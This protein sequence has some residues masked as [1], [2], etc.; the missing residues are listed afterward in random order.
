MPRR[1]YIKRP[2]APVDLPWTVPAIAP[3]Y[4]YPRGTLPGG[5]IIGIGELGGGWTTADVAANFASVGQP[6]PTIVDVSVGGAT[7]SPGND[8]DYEVM[9]DIVMAGQAYYCV[10][11]KPATIRVYWAP[12]DAVGI[13]NVTDQAAADGC[14]VLSWSWGSD[15]ADWG[16]A[17]LD[18]METSAT[19]AT[20]AGMAVFAAAGD[21]DSSD[22][23][24]TASNVDA[25]ASCPHVV[26][27]GGTSRP[28]NITTHAQETVWN[29]NPGL[30]NG[31]GTGGGWSKHFPVQ[32]WQNGAPHGSGRM[33][34]DLAA[35]ADP[36]TGWTVLVH[37][38]W[39]TIGGTS[40]VA[41]LMAGFFAGCGKKPGWV[42]PKLWMYQLAFWDVTN[43]DNGAYRAAVGPDACSG[44]GVPRGG[45]VASHFVK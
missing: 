24:A 2:R 27:C 36:Q 1:S 30:T 32:S 41:P 17:A 8:A 21:N 38:T 45:R 7:N 29:N 20:A 44:L 19:K 3:E 42:T 14:D 33:V 5:G 18:Q 6:V 35:N 22:G 4:G 37:G 10:T 12:N 23:G 26:A 9:L 31:E 40:A 16:P 15:E 43:G 39:T 13:P 34:P 11:G 28:H 25:P